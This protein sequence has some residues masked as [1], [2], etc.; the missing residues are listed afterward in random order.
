MDGREAVL[1]GRGEVA[2]DSQLFHDDGGFG[3]YFIGSGAVVN[4]AEQADQTAHERRVGI[5]AKTAAALFHCGC[6][7]YPGYATADEVAFHALFFLQ[8]V[9]GGLPACGDHEALLGIGDRTEGGPDRLLPLSGQTH[10]SIRISSQVHAQL[11]QLWDD[12]D[13]AIGVPRLVAVV[14]ILM[15]ALGGIEGRGF[16]DLRDDGAGE[17]RLR[18]GL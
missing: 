6:Q 5:H 13:L 15:I 8:R 3:Y 17:L 9:H 18:G 16:R 7:P 12:H 2:Q 11:F 1:T 4:A 10:G 14:V